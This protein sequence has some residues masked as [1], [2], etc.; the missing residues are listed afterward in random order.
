ML[1]FVALMVL[2]SAAILGVVYLSGWFAVVPS[3]TTEIVALLALTT[4]VIFYYLLNWSQSKGQMFTQFYLLSIAVKLVA[5][6]AF[7]A[8]IVVTDP[9]MAVGNTVLFLASYILF[10]F[11]EVL[12]LFRKVN[13]S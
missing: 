2:L 4:L 13:H 7:I 11:L 8:I 5:Y 12:F 1:I 9:T 3:Y 6:G 10:T